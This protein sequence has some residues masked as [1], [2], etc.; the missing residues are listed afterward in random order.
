MNAITEALYP[1]HELAIDLAAEDIENGASQSSDF[2]SFGAVR[3]N[4]LEAHQ[5][6]RRAQ[7]QGVQPGYHGDAELRLAQQEAQDTVTL[8][9]LIRDFNEVTRLRL[10]MIASGSLDLPQSEAGAL[11]AA[12]T[13]INILVRDILCYLGLEVTGVTGGSDGSYPA[14]E[15][16]RNAQ[17][18]LAPLVDRP[19]AL[20]ASAASLE[21]WRQDLTVAHRALTRPHKPAGYDT[22][23]HVRAWILENQGNARAPLTQGRIAAGAEVQSWEVSR[24][25]GKLSATYSPEIGWHIG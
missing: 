15:M 23:V 24:D 7:A 12:A 17:A 3:F 18:A 14:G 11:D 1:L 4:L 21:G 10:R 16:L 25:L 8:A 6:L 13:A 2:E 22:S 19:R 20:A 5:H 9:E